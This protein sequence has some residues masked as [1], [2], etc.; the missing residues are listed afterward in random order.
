MAQ[1]IASNRGSI[2]SFLL[3]SHLLM[4]RHVADQMFVVEYTLLPVWVVSR[5]PRRHRRRPY[6]TNLPT[7]RSENGVRALSLLD[8]QRFRSEILPR[9]GKQMS[10]EQRTTAPHETQS[11][12]SEGEVRER[13]AVK[14]GRKIREK[15]I[16]Q[17]FTAKLYAKL[18]LHGRLRRGFEGT[19]L[20]QSCRLAF[21]EISFLVCL[22][23]VASRFPSFS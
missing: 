4:T 8:F 23:C 11:R 15:G 20:K 16:D 19:I 17:I 7:Q 9:I 12:V 3:A 21:V 13:R 18:W 2:K 14:H 6:I 10:F 5:R 22:F 1:D